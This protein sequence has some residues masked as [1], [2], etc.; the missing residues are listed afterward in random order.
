MKGEDA[1]KAMKDACR[2][3]IEEYMKPG[4]GVPEHWKRCSSHI[5]AQQES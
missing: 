4:S 2:E 5:P 1:M 3:E